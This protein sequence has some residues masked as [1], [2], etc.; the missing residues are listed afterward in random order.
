[1]L[2]RIAT[3]A[4]DFDLQD[5][6][7]YGGILLAAVG[8]WHLSPAWTCIMVGLVLVALGVFAPRRAD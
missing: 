7:I 6:H 4:R 2:K 3:I 5:G 1:L 8:G